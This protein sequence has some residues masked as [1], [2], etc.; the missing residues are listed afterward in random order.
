MSLVE[1][2]TVVV[3]LK[4]VIGKV[5]NQSLA[6]GNPTSICAAAAVKIIMMKMLYIVSISG[7]KLRIATRCRCIYVNTGLLKKHGTGKIVLEIK[8]YYYTVSARINSDFPGLSGVNASLD[9]VELG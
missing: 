5:N 2:P 3:T 6:M 7:G 1:R 9:K 4:L 8:Y